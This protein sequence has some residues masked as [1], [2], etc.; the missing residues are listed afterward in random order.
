MFILITFQVTQTTR[1]C[2]RNPAVPSRGRV[3]GR[4]LDSWLHPAEVR[5]LPAH[6]RKMASMHDSIYR[7]INKHN[8]SSLCRRVAAVSVATR[9]AQEMGVRLGEEVGYMVS[10]HPT[11]LG[12]QF[13][14][15]LLIPLPYHLPHLIGPFRPQVRPASHEGGVHDRR[16]AVARDHHRPSAVA[17]LRHSRGRGEAISSPR[18]YKVRP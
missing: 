14:I 5:M 10:N 16:H 6:T 1:N 11:I 15:S 18:G 4:W 7:R 17:V 2:S 3:D 8:L 9:V 13:S 12:W